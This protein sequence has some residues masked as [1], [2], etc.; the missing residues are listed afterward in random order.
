LLATYYG[1]RGLS[2]MFLPLLLSD[3]VHPPMVFFIVFYGLDWVARGTRGWSRPRADSLRRPESAPVAGRTLARGIIPVRGVM[4]DGDD[5]GR[6]RCGR[7]G[8]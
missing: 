5:G 2:L 1:L 6:G 7:R 4:G 3:T 8:W